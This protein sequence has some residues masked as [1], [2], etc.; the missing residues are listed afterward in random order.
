MDEATKYTLQML[1]IGPVAT[2]V[3]AANAAMTNRR[4][5]REL[6]AHNYGA[7]REASNLRREIGSIQHTMGG[8]PSRGQLDQDA[9]TRAHT[10]AA[11]TPE[12]HDLIRRMVELRN[13]KRFGG[14]TP[15]LRPGQAI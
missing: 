3:N 9:V 1:G 4:E 15:M 14:N 10:G 7:P 2:G 11:A 12:E 6:D 5:Q 13:R 8:F